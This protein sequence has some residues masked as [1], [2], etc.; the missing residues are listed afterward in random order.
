MANGQPLD[1]NKITVAYNK[2]KLGTWVQIVNQKTLARVVA[3]VTD[4][5]GYE[6]HGKIIDITPAT[7]DA[8]GCSDTC[9]VRVQIL[10]GAQ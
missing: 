2:A 3:I 8:L 1:D 5:G 9:Q 4:R 6:R 10:G 7:R